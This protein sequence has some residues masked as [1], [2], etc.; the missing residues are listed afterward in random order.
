MGVQPVHSGGGLGGGG[1]SLSGRG[2]SRP[3]AG[4]GSRQ[5]SADPCSLP[6]TPCSTSRP[7]PSLSRCNQHLQ[8]LRRAKDANGLT[9]GAGLGLNRTSKPPHG[10][11]RGLT[12]ISKPPPTR[13]RRAPPHPLASRRGPDWG[14]NPFL[15]TELSHRKV[16]ERGPRRWWRSTWGPSGH[17]RTLGPRR[18]PSRVTNGTAYPPFPPMGPT[19]LQPP[20]E[21]QPT[22]PHPSRR[23][24]APGLCSARTQTGIPSH[25]QACRSGACMRRA[26]MHSE[27][28]IIPNPSHLLTPQLPGE[29]TISSARR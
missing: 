3:T 7:P 14:L 22:R 15:N 4:Q 28:H 20:S 25:R 29:A 18:S 12:R 5:G 11:G 16:C 13:R 19:A 23:N 26:R 2:V 17:A 21:T 9:P 1:S 6:L 10:A 27:Q 24:P 8:P